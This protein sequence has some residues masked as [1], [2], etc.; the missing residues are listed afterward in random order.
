MELLEGETLKNLTSRRVDLTIGELISYFIKAA[1]YLS[2]LHKKGIYHRD[3][4]PSNIFITKENSVKILDFGISTTST[5]ENSSQNEI[6]GS[7]LYTAPEIFEFLE[8]LYKFF[9]KM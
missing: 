1:S 7:L 4:K 8:F 6:T 5:R 9:R 2:F 3:V